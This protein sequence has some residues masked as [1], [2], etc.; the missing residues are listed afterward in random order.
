MAAARG[1]AG[2]VRRRPRPWETSE[3]IRVLSDALEARAGDRLGME[4]A[5]HALDEAAAD[6][7]ERLREVVAELLR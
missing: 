3:T 7:A 6:R 2:A 5:R 1:S 4:R